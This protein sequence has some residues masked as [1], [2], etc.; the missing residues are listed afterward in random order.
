MK[1]SKVTKLSRKYTQYDIS[2]ET[3]N[4]Y[5]KTENSYVLIHNSPALFM[6]RD[7]SDGEF[8]VAK[9]GLFNKN[10]KLYKTPQEIDV[11]TSGDLAEKL[12]TALEYG[13]TLGVRG[14]IQGDLLYTKNDLETVK[15][16]GEEFIKFHP[17]TIAYMVPKKSPLGKK[18]LRSEIGIV[19]HT[20]YSGDSLEN[21]SASF[22]KTIADKLAPTS[23]VWSVDATYKDLSGTVTFTD[24]E[25]KEITKILSEAG[26]IFQRLPKSALDGLSQNEQLGIMVNT[27]INSKVRQGQKITNPRGFAVELQKY[28]EE[29]FEKEIEKR[30][31][32]NAKNKQKQK[33]D[34]VMNYFK[35]TPSSVLTQVFELYNLLAEAKLYFVRKLDAIGDVKTM[36]RTK[37]G[38]EVTGAEGFV[39]IDRTGKN[40]VKLVDRMQFSRANFSPDYIKGWS[41]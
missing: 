13:K 11:D 34:E 6:G 7:P 23:K 27:F 36:L 32:D 39:A 29:R 3:E 38:Y 21:M 30:K 25:T 35:K 9:K 31:T 40:A 22:G 28:I 24:K 4:F 17:N 10:P 33:R 19:W 1:V 16:D 18:I 2:T 41:K 8:F 14:V 37:D 12:K 15:L 26:R 5:V 20:T